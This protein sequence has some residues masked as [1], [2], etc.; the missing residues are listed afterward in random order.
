MPPGEGDAKTQYNLARKELAVPMLYSMNIDHLYILD[1]PYNY[2]YVTN[3]GKIVNISWIPSQIGIHG[4][5]EADLSLQNP[6]S[7]L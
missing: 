4:N 5:D 7:K 1:I 2:Y 3:Q 6:S